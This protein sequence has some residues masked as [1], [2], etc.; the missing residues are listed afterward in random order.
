MP[1]I[2]VI[3]VVIVILFSNSSSCCNTVNCWCSCLTFVCSFSDACGEFV[4]CYRCSGTYGGDR[5]RLGCCWSYICKSSCC[6][7]KSRCRFH[8]SHFMRICR[9]FEMGWS[10]LWCGNRC[11]L[12]FCLVGRINHKRGNFLSDQL[13]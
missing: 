7:Y 6:C 13:H 10:W 9:C 1:H 5:R 12:M 11:K 2:A 3:V 8:K 4:I